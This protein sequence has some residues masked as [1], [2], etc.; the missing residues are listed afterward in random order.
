MVLVTKKFVKNPGAVLCGK[1]NVKEFLD[2][3]PGLHS[4]CLVNGFANYHI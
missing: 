4:I 1:I 3:Q 2:E